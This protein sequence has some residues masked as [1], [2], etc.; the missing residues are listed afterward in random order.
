MTIFRAIWMGCTG[1]MALAVFMM[2]EGWAYPL[3]AQTDHQ[4]A[5]TVVVTPLNLSPGAK[6]WDFEVSLSTHT[7]PLDHDMKRAAVLV[8][9]AGNAHAPLAWEGDPPGGHHRK[10]VLQFQPLPTMPEFIELRISGVGSVAQRVFRWRL[11]E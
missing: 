4:N 9:G 5:V 11:S 2:G 7:V 6:Q 8:D 10:G 1:A 3:D